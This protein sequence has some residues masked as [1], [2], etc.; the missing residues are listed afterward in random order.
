MKKLGIN[1]Q[2]LKKAEAIAGASNPMFGEV[3]KAEFV[4][5]PNAIKPK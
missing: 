4:G 1:E 2:P 5:N 3:K